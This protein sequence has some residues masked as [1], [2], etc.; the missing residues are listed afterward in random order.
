MTHSSWG[1]NLTAGEAVLENRLRSL[2]Q[3]Q[4]AV[5]LLS[6]SGGPGHSLVGWSRRCYLLLCSCFD[7]T[8]PDAVSDIKRKNAPDLKGARH[9]PGQTDNQYPE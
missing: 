9:S 8:A 1:E 6:V 3:T 2:S 7:S 4:R 5:S